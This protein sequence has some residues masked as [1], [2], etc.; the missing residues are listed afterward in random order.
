MSVLIQH[1]IYV[2]LSYTHFYKKKVATHS[3]RR[4]ESESESESES[5]CECESECESE[6]ERRLVVM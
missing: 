6:I 5:K 3:T 4:R 1:T 2:D